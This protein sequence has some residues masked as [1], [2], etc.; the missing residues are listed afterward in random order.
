MKKLL[1]TL[2]LLFLAGS[3][4]A[5][6]QEPLNLV[7]HADQGRD[8]I[9]RHIYGHF[10]EHLGRDIYDGFWTRA[11]TGEWHLRDDVIEALKRI[12]AWVPVD[13]YYD[14][15]PGPHQTQSAQEQLY[16]LSQCMSCG[17]CVEACPQ[18]T[19]AELTQQ[20]G[21]SREDFEKRKGELYDRSFV[22]PHAISQAVL[23]N[24]NPIGR[25]N[26]DER[27]DA[28]MDE[29]GIQ[30]CGNAQNCVAVCPKE[31]PLTTS[32]ARAGRST[33]WRAFNRWFDQKSPSR[34][35][36]R[37]RRVPGRLAAL[38]CLGA[39]LTA[40][41]RGWPLT[42][43]G[44][45][46]ND[47]RAGRTCFDDPFQFV[48]IDRLNFDQPAGHRLER[49]TAR[50]QDMPY[51][52]D[53]FVNDPS[54]FLVDFTGRLFAV[55]ASGA[56]RNAGQERG[57]GRVAVVDASQA[58][59]SVFHHHAASDLRRSL[60]IV[61]SAGGDIRV[62]KFLGN[63]AGQQNLNPALQLGLRHQE[64]VTLGPLHGVSQ[65]RQTARNDRHFVNRIGIGQTERHQSVATLVVGHAQLFIFVHHALLLFQTGRDAFHSF[66]ELLHADGVLLA[67]GGQQ[68]RFVNQVGQVSA[69]EAGTD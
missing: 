23:F 43:V 5:S 46:G 34:A 13:G 2:L 10:A 7:I 45:A 63:R 40:F 18:Y 15:G 1:P 12:R 39:T 44:G 55:P 56:F 33:T 32:I 28:L 54:H 8:T 37:V 47:L 50:L 51:L 58:T 4:R 36:C 57:A 19:K 27:L 59:H 64:A 49:R 17:C 21:E 42:S 6:A 20:E 62:D 29:G 69:D 53:R 67:A 16:P 11:G 22:G 52:L 14:M 3:P 68:C 41:G 66:V 24:A 30:V 61:L 25:N 35:S 26:A 65:S 48:R 60:Q 31:I 38:F 9:S